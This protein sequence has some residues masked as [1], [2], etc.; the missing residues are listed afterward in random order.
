M[1]L[2]RTIELCDATHMLIFHQNE[3]GTESQ[4]ATTPAHKVLKKVH[5][6]DE[7]EKESCS[8][9]EGTVAI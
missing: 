3:D 8:S 2:H 1:V 7:E 4:K 5:P 6:K 9:G